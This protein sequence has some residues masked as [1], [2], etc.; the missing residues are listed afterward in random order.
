MGQAGPTPLAPTTY[1]YPEA[2]WED[3]TEAVRD[4]RVGEV[5]PGLP[6]ASHLDP[7]EARLCQQP[8]PPFLGSSCTAIL[9]YTAQ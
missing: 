5:E 7:L 2:L 8:A 6:E 4:G 1:G 9:T 3:G